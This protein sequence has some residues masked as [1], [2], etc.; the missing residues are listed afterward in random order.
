MNEGIG[1]AL[2]SFASM[3]VLAALAAW[4]CVLPTI[5]LLWSIGWL[6]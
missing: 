3:F 5:G 6:K 1:I 4:F 2:A